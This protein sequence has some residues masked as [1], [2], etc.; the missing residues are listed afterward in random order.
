M[1]C[2]FGCFLCL[3]AFKWCS[4][5]CVRIA[6]SLLRNGR[7]MPRKVLDVRK[8]CV[9]LYCRKGNGKA[10]LGLYRLAL[11]SLSIHAPQR[12]TS[13]T[14]WNKWSMLFPPKSNGRSSEKRKTHGGSKNADAEFR[15]D[16]QA[17]QRERPRPLGFELSAFFPARSVS[18][19]VLDRGAKRRACISQAPAI[20]PFS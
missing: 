12:L 13:R 14:P 8:E 16:S 1:Y 19:R 7:F 15:R 4:Y 2:V 18:R 6:L 10:P 9:R 17:D 20:V 11:S 3:S 5:K